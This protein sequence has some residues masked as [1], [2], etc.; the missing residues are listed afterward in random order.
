METINTLR[1]DINK[2]NSDIIE[3]L[4]K[5]NEIS[6]K[7]GNEKRKLGLP[8]YDPTRE[9]QIYEKIKSKHPENYKQLNA[10]FEEIIKQ[11]RIIQN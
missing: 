5:R 7:I 9:S 6:K 4:L 10:V 3:L 2:V 1:E 11:S 8:V